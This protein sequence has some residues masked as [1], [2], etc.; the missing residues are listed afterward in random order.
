M[1]TPEQ[2]S[3]QRSAVKTMIELLNASPEAGAIEWRERR[4][5]L[6]AVLNRK[7]RNGPLFV[8]D[9]DCKIVRRALRGGAHYP[10]DA[11]G[12]VTPTLEAYKRASGL[13]SHPTDCV[14]LGA[15]KLFPLPDLLKP[16]K[17]VKRPA[18]KA[19]G[20]LSWLGR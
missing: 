10:K 11:L 16:A 8:V 1:A 20:A 3:S 13:H 6:K 15:A 4:E 7:L 19:G 12:R 2:S 9:P 18:K 14:M 17:K 5:S